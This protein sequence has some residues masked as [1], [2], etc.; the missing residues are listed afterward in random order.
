MA[1][2]FSPALFL[3]IPLVASQPSFGGGQK[4]GDTLYKVMPK[5]QKVFMDKLIGLSI[6]EKESRSI[7]NGLARKDSQTKL[8]QELAS[9]VNG[10]NSTLS[11]R[12]IGNWIGK[13]NVSA[14]TLTLTCRILTR[15]RTVVNVV[16]SIQTA[17][18]KRDVLEAAKTLQRGDLVRFSLSSDQKMPAHFRPAI[19]TVYLQVRVPSRLL[20]A[21][22]VVNP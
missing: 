13:P 15:E 16:F 21:I 11:T 22:S 3:V 5:D 19:S 8:K 10:I 6:L 18:M 9:L 7:K 17:G 4:N 2:F 20:S 1:R 14:Q 12:G